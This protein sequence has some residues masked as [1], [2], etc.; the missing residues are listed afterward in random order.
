MLKQVLDAHALAMEQP[1]SRLEIRMYS[2]LRSAGLPPARFQH[3]V[4]CRGEDYRID[5]AYPDRM[6]AIEVDGFE[7]RSTPEAMQRDLDRQ[8]DLVEAGWTVVRFTWHD[9]VRRPRRVATRIARVLGA[10]SADI[11]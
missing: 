8:N 3:W 2:L 4:L 9:I 6:V 11:R 1:D 5:F 7:K 10:D